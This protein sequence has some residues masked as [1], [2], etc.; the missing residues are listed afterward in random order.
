MVVFVVIGVDGCFYINLGKLF[1]DLKDVE[2]FEFK[3]EFVSKL[4][5][6]IKLLDVVDFF[7]KIEVEV[8]IGFV[9]ICDVK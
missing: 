5:I 3:I 4:I 8:I 6:F 7:L 9:K 2:I 1:L